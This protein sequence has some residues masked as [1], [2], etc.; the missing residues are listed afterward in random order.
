[1]RSGLRAAAIILSF[2]LGFT[3]AG[4]CQS[5]TLLRGSVTDPQGASIPD[6][7]EHEPRFRAGRDCTTGIALEQN[8]YFRYN[9]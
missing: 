1:M 6:A 7:S 4:Y 2:G 5:T 8:I 3:T 9:I